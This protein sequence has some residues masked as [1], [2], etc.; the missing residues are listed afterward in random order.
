MIASF[1]A[2]QRYFIQFNTSRNVPS[3]RISKYLTRIS[4]LNKTRIEL[5]DCQKTPS[6]VSIASQVETPVPSNTDQKVTQ[7]ESEK[8]AEK[9]DLSIVD[10]LNDSVEEHQDSFI[11]MLTNGK[12]IFHLCIQSY[13]FILLNFSYWALSLY[14]TELHENKY[15]GYFLSGLIE[16]PGGLLA[17]VLLMYVGR[18]SVTALGL[19]GQGA[20]MFAAI[21]FPDKSMA[22]M[23]CILMVKLF[24]CAV[25]NSAPL[26]ASELAP[27]STRNRFYGLVSFMGEFGAVFAPYISEL[28]RI[29]DQGPAILI[30]AMSFI[31]VIAVCAAP[32]T[33]D[34]PLPENLEDFDEGPFLR[35]LSRKREKKNLRLDTQKNENAVMLEIGKQ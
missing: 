29:H 27:T 23:I 11:D 13:I 31:A 22:S 20:F 35:F 30:T 25:W 14:S 15:T 19:I 24:N 1:G 4:K 34:K 8:E 3:K 28:K 6:L 9:V 33:K 21:F 5:D 32:E 18:K 12:V 16:L 10:S 7:L 17:I 2:H 26:M